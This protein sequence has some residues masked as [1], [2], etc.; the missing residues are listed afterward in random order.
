[1]A[2]TKDGTAYDLTGPESA[3]VV[4]L[5]HGL[6]LTRGATWDGIAPVLARRFRVLSYD[7]LGHGESA[8]PEG[9]VNLTALSEQVIALMDAL[10]IE[11]SALVGFSLGGMINR[12]CALDH[13][14]RVSALAIL[15]SP[16]DRG[17]EQQQIVEERARAS[18]SGGPA[19]GIDV[20]LARWFTEEFRRDH[21]EQVAAIRDTVLAN[22][23]ANYAAH[24]QV[25]AEGVRE[26]IAPDP[27]LT[28]PMLV[29]TCAHDSGSTPAMSHAIAAETPGAETII[30]PE[31]Q[32]LGLIEQPGLF[33]DPLLDF[34]NRVL[35]T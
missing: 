23:P 12:R 4:V 1:M 9:P 35:P 26:L 13:P 10:G 21:P 22:D 17:E 3:P 25:L 29:M 32:H 33:S 7:L 20:T 27:P 6:G 8:R 14:G 30:V 19:A 18:A 15:N 34:L 2:V 28:H 31:L 24:R 5:I 11:R 16:H